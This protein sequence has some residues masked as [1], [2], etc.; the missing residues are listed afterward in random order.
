MRVAVIMAG[1]SGERF[2]PLSRHD[3]PKQLLPLAGDASMLRDTVER[4]ARVVGI[5]N[6]HIVAGA[7][8]I[9]AIQRDLAGRVAEE[10]LIAEPEGKNTA[11]CLALAAA[12]I[13]HRHGPETLMGVFTAD[14]LIRNLEVFESNVNLAFDCAAQPDAL[15]TIGIRPT[16]ANTGFGYLELGPEV[17]S[18][19]RG[20]VRQVVRFHEK[21]DEATARAYVEAGRFLWN[22]GMFFWRIATLM[23]AFRA[24]CPELAEGAE[25]I[26]KACGTPDRKRTV[27]E[28]FDAWP[29]ISIDYAVME[30]AA[31]VCA[32]TSEFDWDDVGTWSA[33]ARI[34]PLDESGNLLTGEV[35]ALDTRN[36]IVFNR[37][38]SEDGPAE[39]KFLVATLGVEDLIVVH[40]G[41]ALLVCHRNREQDLK[42]LLKTLREQGREG[43]L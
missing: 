23:Q 30:K 1:G 36:C 4:T 33:L 2:W 3:R 13:A 17:F 12:R 11:P 28:V 27:L 34:H 26:M 14:H 31:G 8:L 18:N 20:G 9:P 38:L 24:H 19:E 21:P 35:A 16:H 43:Y 39:S 25:R 22:S 7:A 6:V 37:P 15:V 32:V 42:K 40:A 5:E 10:N 29:A 41:D